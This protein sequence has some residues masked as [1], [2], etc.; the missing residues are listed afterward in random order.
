MQ[1]CA[2]T[3]RCST[4]REHDIIIIVHHHDVVLLLMEEVMSSVFYLSREHPHTN[5]LLSCLT[6][7]GV[8]A[9]FKHINKRRK[10]N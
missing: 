6:K 3:K 1:V 10:R 5:I 4:K 9:E 7:R 2:T 8:P